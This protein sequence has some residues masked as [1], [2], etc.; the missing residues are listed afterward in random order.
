MKLGLKYTGIDASEG[1][2][3]IAKNR[4]QAGKFLIGDFYKLNFPEN[5]FDSFWAATSFL[6]V[7]KADISLV[8]QEAKRVVKPDAIGF[9]SLKTKTIMDEGYI[10]EEKAGGIERYFSFYTQE[11]FENILKKNG[12]EILLATIKIEKDGTHW[13]CNIVKVKKIASA[14]HIPL[15]G[16]SEAR[17][18]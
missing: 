10:K 4:V 6:H 9:I 14:L 2:I 8:L 15:K 17:R 3:A 18:R 1:M 12:F 7:P 5:T 13:L 11:E 16:V